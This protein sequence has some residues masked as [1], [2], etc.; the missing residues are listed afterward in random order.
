MSFSSADECR[1]VQSVDIVRVLR[2]CRT[3]IAPKE[4][5]AI[6]ETLQLQDPLARAA[7]AESS[8][9]N[10]AV[11]DNFDKSEP[12]RRLRNLQ[13]RLKQITE[14]KAKQKKGEQLEK[15]QVLFVI[16]E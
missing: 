1:L 12:E 16:C 5:A 13:K 9:L 4:L 3:D 6:L 10:S 14:L 11:S 7:A 8:S 15:N 2:V